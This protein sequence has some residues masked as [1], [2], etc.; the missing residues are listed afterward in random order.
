M[1][2]MQGTTVLVLNSKSA[3]V[4]AGQMEEFVSVPS[5]V[6]LYATGS[7]TGLLVNMIAG[8]AVM[9][10]DQAIGFQ[11]RFPL[12]PDDFIYEFGATGPSDR[13][14]LTF[15]NPTGGSITAF[16]RVDVVPV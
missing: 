8:G 7:V 16:W 3:N 5:L 1:G 15:R 4:L 13:L 2:V 6:R 10:D 14:I 11:N 9:I 12:V